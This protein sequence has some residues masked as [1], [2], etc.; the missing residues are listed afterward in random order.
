MRT[1]FSFLSVVIL[2]PIQVFAQG[3]DTIDDSDGQGRII[4]N[5]ETIEGQASCKQQVCYLRGYRMAYTDSGLF[6][7]SGAKANRILV[8]N[9]KNGDLGIYLDKIDYNNVP[10]LNDAIVQSFSVGNPQ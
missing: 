4:I 9:F 2:L 6:I 3:F 7:G 8:K 10:H 5:G 1:I